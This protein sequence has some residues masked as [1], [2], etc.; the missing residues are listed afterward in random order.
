MK[1]F[2]VF[3]EKIAVKLKTIPE[4]GDFAGMYF[5][6]AKL[7]LIDPQYPNKFQTLVHECIHAV[8]NRTGMGQTDLS[9][10][11]EELIC[12]NIA[13]FIN[14]NIVQLYQAHNKFKK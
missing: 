8:L 14:E 6:Q 3:G 7:I 13:T 2:N 4:N 5:P 12:E 10:D 11:Q 9:K 1:K